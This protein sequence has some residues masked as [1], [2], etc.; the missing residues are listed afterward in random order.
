MGGITR[1]NTYALYLNGLRPCKGF[2]CSN[3]FQ[4]TK[5]TDIDTASSHSPCQTRHGTPISSL[6]NI[7]PAT[8]THRVHTCVVFYQ[9]LA[10]FLYQ[11]R[12]RKGSCQ[13]RTWL[14]M[15]TSSDGG[16][17]PN[18]ACEEHSL[19][20]MDIK[21]PSMGLLFKLPAVLSKK[22]FSAPSRVMTQSCTRQEKSPPADPC[23]RLLLQTPT[24]TLQESPVAA[25]N[26]Q[27]GFLHT[28]RRG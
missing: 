13:S 7:S 21:G 27:G 15:N 8:H 20:Q 10:P 11:S 26:M 9:R 2:F 18:P 1:I 5:G 12:L 4:P 24:S 17:F 22:L 6:L 16:S 3:S 14:H 25:A 19:Q 28:A 23:I